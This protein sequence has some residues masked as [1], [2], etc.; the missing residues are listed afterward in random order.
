VF[1]GSASRLGARSNHIK[2]GKTMSAVRT[3][4]YKK[5]KDERRSDYEKNKDERRSICGLNEII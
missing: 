2:R 1:A 4:D 5:S 3:S